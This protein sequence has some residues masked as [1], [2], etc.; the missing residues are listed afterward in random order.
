MYSPNSSAIS[1]SP[2][3]PPG[4]LCSASY[5]RADHGNCPSAECQPINAFTATINK[6]A[7]ERLPLIERN[8][9]SSSEPNGKDVY[10]R[11]IMYVLVFRV[12]AE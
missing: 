7:E 5:R 11:E 2:Q 9:Q 12:E 3:P 6:K 4:D 10:S 8:R 1:S